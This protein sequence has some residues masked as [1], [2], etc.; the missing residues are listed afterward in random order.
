MVPMG[1]SQAT[2]YQESV[3]RWT[4]RDIQ[5][6]FLFE[7]AAIFCPVG[8][9]GVITSIETHLI[10]PRPTLKNYNN[11]L[12][13]F[14]WE[15]DKG[16]PPRYFLRAERPQWIETRAPWPGDSSPF[17]P[18]LPFGE[19]A[20]WYDSRYGWSHTGT[21]YPL[22]L[23]IPENSVIRLYQAIPFGAPGEEI[24]HQIAGRLRGITQGYRDC[25]QARHTSRLGW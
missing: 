9:H 7:L 3:E 22:R 5:P 18:G 8:S 23:Q 13:P 25:A 21:A 11:P 10:G 2:R 15:A 6:G 1:D 16:A 19:L 4:G 14:E 20:S 24:P 17:L 12:N